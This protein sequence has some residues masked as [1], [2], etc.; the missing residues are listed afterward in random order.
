[1]IMIII[2][3]VILTGLVL[4]LAWASGVQ[5]QVARAEMRQDHAFYAA[6]SG[7]Q[8]G[9]WQFKHDNTFRRTND[10][11]YTLNVA[12]GSETYACRVTC[13]D[14]VGTATLAWKF[15][16]GTGSTTVDSSGH[17]NTGT[18]RGGAQWTTDCRSGH[19]IQLNGSTAYVDCGNGPST[20]ITGDITFSAWVKLAGA[21]YDQKVGANQ[22]GM[23]GGYKLCV[24]N[25][26]LEFEVRDAANTAWLNR[27]QPGGTTLV[28]GTWYHVVGVYSESGHWIKTYVNGQEETTR[29]LTGLPACALSTTTGTFIIGREPFDDS[30]YFWNGNIDDVRIFN[31]ALSDTEIR[32]LYDTTVDLRCTATGPGNVTGVAAVTTSVPSPPPPTVPTVT[33]GS[34]VTLRSCTIVG[35]LQ[36]SQDVSGS[37][38]TSSTIDGEVYYGTNYNP[39]GKITLLNNHKAQ[40]KSSSPPSIN[41]STLQAQANQVYNSA[42]NGTTFNFSGLGGN[43]VIYV[44]GNVTD[45]KF[46]FSGVYPSGGTLV[47]NGQLKFNTSTT[48][49]TP[50]YP[51]YLVVRQDCTQNTGAKLTLYGGL[52]VET[53]WNRQQVDVTG[54]VSIKGGLNDNAGLPSTFTNSAIPWF[55]SRSTNG[56]AT[57]PMYY[58]NFHDDNP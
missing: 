47:I 29:R 17:G 37:G 6:E 9:I 42:Q 2:L 49:G 19:G 46:A 31:R 24:Y 52:Y 48:V 27:N 53:N 45:P 18:F 21:Y 10:A 54:V 39:N 3:A 33:C 43:K 58:L 28:M 34:N 7:L 40:K 35:D 55:D 38:S 25:T 16:E 4:A 11:P 13:V 5:V 57:L 26:K 1:M 23:F 44:N 56:Q 32:S 36:V 30:L 22:N 20:N 8:A 14:S 51:V 50:T 12:M 41:Y 15:D